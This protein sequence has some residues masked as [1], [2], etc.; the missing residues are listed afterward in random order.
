MKIYILFI[1]L[2]L[3]Y[4]LPYV[5]TDPPS[6]YEQVLDSPVDEIVWCGSQIVINEDDEIVKSEIDSSYKKKMFLITDKGVVYRT[7]NNGKT[8]ENVT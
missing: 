5:K 7:A 2:F 3:F 4:N 6:V 8:W 1:V